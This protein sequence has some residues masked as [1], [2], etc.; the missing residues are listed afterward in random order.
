M[1][2]AGGIVPLSRAIILSRYRNGGGGL[3]MRRGRLSRRSRKSTMG[4]G[5]M[6]SA[7]AMEGDALSALPATISLSAPH[8]DGVFVA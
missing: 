4:A 1:I 5:P 3:R 8:R 2:G 6:H 7:R